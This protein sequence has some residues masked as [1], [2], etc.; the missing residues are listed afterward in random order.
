MIVE[1]DGGGNGDGDWEEKGDSFAATFLCWCCKGKG[2]TADDVDK[3]LDDHQRHENSSHVLSHGMLSTSDSQIGPVM[4]LGDEAERKRSSKRRK[5]KKGSNGGRRG[6]E[7][8]GKSCCGKTCARA[9]R[10]PSR[11]LFKWCHI[12]RWSKWRVTVCVFYA[13]N[14]VIYATCVMLIEMFSAGSK[15]Y[16]YSVSLVSWCW[17][18]FEPVCFRLPPS[19]YFRQLGFESIYHHPSIHQYVYVCITLHLL[20]TI[21]FYL[22]I[23]HLL[24]F[25]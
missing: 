17:L 13:L 3:F 19:L 21:Y 8:G 1:G 9:F 12:S 22:F 18:V 20:P 23:T 2:G 14:L 4:I 24:L 7:K 6:R 15:F 5:R 16:Y 10:R 11:R 25:R